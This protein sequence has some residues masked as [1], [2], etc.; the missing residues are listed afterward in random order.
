M[1]SAVSPPQPSSVRTPPALTSCAI[2]RAKRCA[3]GLR[4]E[5]LALDRREPDELR[6]ATRQ[7]TAD[8]VRRRRDGCRAARGQPL[9]LGE[10]DRIVR[11]DR[12][13]DRPGEPGRR[14][15][16][17]AGASWRATAAASPAAP[18]RSAGDLSS[19]RPNGPSKS[20]STRVS[21]TSSA[22]PLAATVAA[23]SIGSATPAPVSRPSTTV[24]PCAGIA[25]ATRARLRPARAAKTPTSSATWPLSRESTF[26]NRISG[27]APTASSAAATAARAAATPP[28]RE[29]VL[30]LRTSGRSARAAATSPGRRATTQ[31]R[32]TR[33]SV[34]ALSSAPVRS[35]AMMRTRMANPYLPF[36]ELTGKY[37]RWKRE[38][39]LP[40]RYLKQIK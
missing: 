37:V 39:R 4:V 12:E 17:R 22:S 6:P 3:C 15:L 11:A 1:A 29:A 10:G 19:A 27:S 13:Q 20:A 8:P 23:T 35:S 5:R 18:T 36:A 34:T 26:L 32:P 9:D 30:T 24:R 38:N 33:V 25:G 21:G 31:R 2:P 40:C 14:D 7:R 16:R 28:S